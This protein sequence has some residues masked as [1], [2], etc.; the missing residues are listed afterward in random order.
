NSDNISEHI[1]DVEKIAFPT[2]GDGLPGA[3]LLINGSD[4]NR[5][6]ANPN[7]NACNQQAD[8]FAANVRKILR[9]HVPHINLVVNTDEDPLESAISEI[10]SGKLS[11]RQAI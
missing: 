8:E 1:E 10:G 9:S 3:V 11:L 5:P 6:D 4:C 2:P 7:A